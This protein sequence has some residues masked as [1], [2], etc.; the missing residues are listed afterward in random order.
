MNI[1]VL[2]ERSGHVRNAF[3]QK[4]HSAISIDQ[5]ESMTP[6]DHIIMDIKNI[7]HDYLSQYDMMIMFPPCTYFSKMNYY[8]DKRD[9][10]REHKRIEDLKLIEYLWNSPV[11]KIAMENPST[12]LLKNYIPISQEIQPYEFGHDYQK[13]TGLWLKNLPPLMATS[14]N[15][16]YQ[17]N[18]TV[19]NKDRTQRI[20]TPK[21][22]AA[23]MAE[24]WG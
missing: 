4:G 10:L 23:A 7:T 19:N 22:L 15:L 18:W 21:G 12:G 9:K 16:N 14:I 1:L 3:N 17:K 13:A 20:I 11:N 5:V 6:G 2:F 8:L 24:Q